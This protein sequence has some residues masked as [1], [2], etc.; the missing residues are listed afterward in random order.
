MIT[1]IDK[2]QGFR[3]YDHHLRH[4]YRE[5]WQVEPGRVFREDKVREDELAVVMV[6]VA[7]KLTVVGLGGGGEFVR[8]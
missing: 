2:Q 4:E 1:N 7:A 3:S 6:A 5:D 8:V